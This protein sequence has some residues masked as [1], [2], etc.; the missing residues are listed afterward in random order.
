MSLSDFRQQVEEIIHSTVE[1]KHSVFYEK[2]KETFIRYPKLMK[3]AC[4]ATD[5][6]AF[7]ARFRY[8]MD[9]KHNID[10]KELTN[11]QADVLIGQHL[12][13]E[14]LPKK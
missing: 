4:E 5:K 14:Y 7:D 3:M 1:N 2:Y 9:M 13:D 12:A 6:K 8:F 11:D 10:S